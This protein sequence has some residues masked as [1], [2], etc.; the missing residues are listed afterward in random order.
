MQAQMTALNTIAKERVLLRRIFLKID[1]CMF[2]NLKEWGINKGQ[3]KYCTY[4]WTK[5]LLGAPVMA[6]DLRASASLI[7]AG[8]AAEGTT[9]IGEFIT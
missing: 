1:L 4:N 5:K 9:E 2:K 6:T 7:L 8:L 3:R